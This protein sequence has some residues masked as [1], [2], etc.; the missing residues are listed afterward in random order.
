[1]TNELFKLPGAF[2]GGLTKAADCLGMN[3]GNESLNLSTLGH[4][5]MSCLIF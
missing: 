1:M 2:E 4:G 5:N 3:D